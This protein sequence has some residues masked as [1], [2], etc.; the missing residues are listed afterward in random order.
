VLGVQI[1]V[2][3]SIALGVYARLSALR[4]RIRE[5]VGEALCSPNDGAEAHEVA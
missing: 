1:C 2:R 3:L 5:P 4:K